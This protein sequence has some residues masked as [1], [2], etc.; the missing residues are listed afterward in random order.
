MKDDIME[1]SSWE[2]KLPRMISSGSALFTATI[3]TMK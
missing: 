1:I 3:L 2:F